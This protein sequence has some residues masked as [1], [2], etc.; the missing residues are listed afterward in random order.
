MHHVE[1]SKPAGFCP[2]SRHSVTAPAF[3]QL[4]VNQGRS[5][6]C[7]GTFQNYTRPPAPMSPPL[8]SLFTK[9]GYPSGRYSNGDKLPDTAPRTLILPVT[10]LILESESAGRRKA[11]SLRPGWA[12]E[13]GLADG[14]VSHGKLSLRAHLRLPAGAGRSAQCELLPTRVGPVTPRN[15]VRQC[16][17]GP[18]RP[19][20]LSFRSLSGLPAPLAL[21]SLS[22]RPG[23]PAQPAACVQWSERTFRTRLLPSSHGPTC[24]RRED[25]TGDHGVAGLWGPQHLK[26]KASWEGPRRLCPQ[27][28]ASGHRHLYDSTA[29]HVTALGS[30]G[31]EKPLCRWK[32]PRGEDE[33]S[34][35]AWGQRGPERTGQEPPQR[36]KE[37]GRLAASGTTR[38][39]ALSSPRRGRPSSIVCG[40]A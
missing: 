18:G 10:V 22:T 12:G 28:P 30:Q 14:T 25:R 39:R 33:G 7:L 2:L 37:D 13:G 26:A 11:E 36:G 38:P 16:R 20:G 27:T 1:K 35:R 34:G 4:G 29:L 15:W 23:A 31:P 6:R 32:H 24:R 5:N 19:L 17:W 9:R 3:S 40:P 8:M 21:S